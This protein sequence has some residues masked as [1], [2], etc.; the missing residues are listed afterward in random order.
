MQ[1]IPANIVKFLSNHHVV[2]IAAVEEGEV[3]AACCFYVF[4][5]AN[6]RLIVLTSL[7]TKHGGMIAG[8]PDSITKIS[9]IQFAAT[10]ALIED[11]VDLKAAQSLYYKAHPAAR[12]MKS[13]VWA[14]NLDSVKFTDNKLVF[15]QKTYWDRKD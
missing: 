3:W 5:E 2:S 6:A 1:T 7:K 12:V 11:E 14:L 4:D 9:G 10:A 8:Q 15:A 13:D